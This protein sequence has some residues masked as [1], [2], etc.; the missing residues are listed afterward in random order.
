VSLEELFAPKILIVSGKGGVGKTTLAAALGIVAARQGRK[1][2]IAEVEAK[3]TLSRLFGA[4]DVTYE[5]SEI[6]PDIFG[7]NIVPEEALAEY[8]RVQY[9]MRRISSV[10]TSTHF[11][12][13]IT[14]AAPGL[15]D[16]L[17]LGKIWYLEQ[18]RGV[19]ED[20]DTIIVDA[21]A[22][23]HMLTFLSA[24]IGLSDALRV[25]PV[26]RQSDWLVQMLQDPSR[27][28]V[29]L[30]TLAE[31]MPVVETLETAQALDHKLGVSHGALFANAI[32]SEL[33]TPKDLERIDQ[34]AV[35]RER[36]VLVKEAAEVGLRIDD[37]DIETLLGYARFLT[38]RRS[39]QAGYLTRLRE[40]TDHPVIEL[41]FL[42][43]AGLALPDIENLAD[44]IEERA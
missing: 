43:S 23:G 40:E 22:A 1:V 29:H 16:I 17:V 26:R 41:P 15:K 12:D 9:R 27:T 14:T 32:Y 6:A 4:E 25:G 19:A 30:V 33:F 34:M 38:A 44:V 31:E 21:P 8:L 39:I 5:P 42:F 13:Y 2:C 7:L 35:G 36:D 24:P 3:A 20:F 28:R 18:N 10:F 11:V 37:E